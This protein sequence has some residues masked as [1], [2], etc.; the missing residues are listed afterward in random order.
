MTIETILSRRL[1]LD[2]CSC[3]DNVRR[4]LTKTQLASVW[5]YNLYCMILFWF[6]C[7]CIHLLIMLFICLWSLVDP[8]ASF[9]LSSRL[10]F[11]LA[12]I[13]TCTCTWVTLEYYNAV[14]M[15]LFNNQLSNDC[16]SETST[17]TNNKTVGPQLLSTYTINTTNRNTKRSCSNRQIDDEST[18][19]GSWSRCCSI[20]ILIYIY[21]YIYI[22]QHLEYSTYL[23]LRS[24]C[25]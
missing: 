15:N 5:L 24:R 11:Q 14:H 17:L 9:L 12:T 10:I 16:G 3:S 21:I 1:P 13:H 20:L 7:C 6:V 2:V 8:N 19:S 23:S 18:H 22:Y 4:A 25:W